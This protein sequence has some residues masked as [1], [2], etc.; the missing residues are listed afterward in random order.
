MPVDRYKENI[1]MYCG[2]QYPGRDGDEFYKHEVDCYGEGEASS[3]D[4]Y[5]PCVSKQVD[6]ATIVAALQE[7]FDR[8]SGIVLGMVGVDLAYGPNLSGANSVVTGVAQAIQLSTPG[9][10]HLWNGN[11]QACINCGVGIQQPGASL[12][13]LGS[14]GGISFAD[15]CAAAWG[16]EPACECGSEKTYGKGASHSSW[17]PKGSK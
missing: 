12:S 3:A 15:A 4:I 9:N 7:C 1:C 6:T 14:S 13:C 17:C 10:Y 8:P 16:K 5:G 2:E 11:S